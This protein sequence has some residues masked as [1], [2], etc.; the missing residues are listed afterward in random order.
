VALSTAEELRCIARQ[1]S[2]T[3]RLLLAD[4]VLALVAYCRGREFLVASPQRLHTTPTEYKYSEVAPDCQEE[5]K[6]EQFA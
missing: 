6:E 4:S 5:E 2:D 1:R 3:R